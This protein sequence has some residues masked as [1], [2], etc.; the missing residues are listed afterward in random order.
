MT[1]SF[2]KVLVN[3]I[4]VAEAAALVL[5]DVAVTHQLNRHPECRVQYRQPPSSRFF[6][7]NDFG[8]SFVVIAGNVEGAEVELF[9]GVLREADA[10]WEL[11]GSAVLT[12]H[13]AGS[14]WVRDSWNRSQ[15]FNMVTPRDAVA[16]L[17]GDLLA[18]FT[19]TQSKPLTLL[20]F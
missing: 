5:L 20:Q 7:E 16:R 14:S 3:G 10:E 17:A 8:K 6:Y 9:R 13:A 19:L 4:D 2:V 12:L 18:D 1:P 11:N 15:T